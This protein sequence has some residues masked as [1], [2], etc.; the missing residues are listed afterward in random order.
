MKSL[1]VYDSFF[2]NTEKIAQ[3]IA[4]ALKAKG[5][6]TLCRI[7]EL[8]LDSLQSINLLVV[9]S[10]TR[11]FNPSKSTTTFLKSIPSRRLEGI[12]VA[13][14]DTR[15]AVED[16]NLWFLTIMVKLFGYAAETIGKRLMQKGGTPLLDPTGFYVKD[17]EGPLKNGEIDRA[18]TW[19][20][21]N[22]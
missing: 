8:S 2:G 18:K 6:V 10:P 22:L 19:L 12:K 3:A 5:D 1:V 20:I 16:V 15:I 21:N 13:A 14:F 4:D 7:A 17:S 11:A 9:G